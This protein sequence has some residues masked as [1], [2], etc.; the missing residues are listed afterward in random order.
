MRFKNASASSRKRANIPHLSPKKI[1]AISGHFDLAGYATK[2]ELEELLKDI[3]V[4]IPSNSNAFFFFAHKK[5]KN[6]FHSTENE[7]NRLGFN[8]YKHPL[9]EKLS[10]V[11]VLVTRHNQILKKIQN[12]YGLNQE[13]LAR[14]ISC[15]SRKV[16]DVLSNKGFFKSKSHQ[17][18]LNQIVR[19]TNDLLNLY[20]ID[21]LKI[22][23]K[24]KNQNFGGKK[25]FD[26]ILKG[27]VDI[28]LGWTYTQLMREYS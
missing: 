23:I 12:I 20:P 21:D 18:V 22:W 5:Q 25:P 11:P 2:D 8:I 7:L 10:D 6:N 4:N 26:M 28:L 14:L 9:S 1:K 13:E 24:A 19:L 27:H 3:N 16:W 15:S 17:N